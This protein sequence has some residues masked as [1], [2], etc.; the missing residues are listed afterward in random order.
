MA[1]TNEAVNLE[2]TIESLP[3]SPIAGTPAGQSYEPAKGSSVDLKAL[4]ESPEFEAFIDKKVQSKQDKRLGQYG[5]KLES[6]EEAISQF[7]ALTKGGMSEPEALAKMRGDQTLAELKAEVASLR[8]NVAVP[9]AGAGEKSWGERQQAILDNAG[10]DKNDPRIVELLR[11]ATS[12]QDFIAKLEANTFVWKQADVKKPVPSSSTVA[13][14]IPSV[15]AGDGT[16]TASKYKQDMIAARGNSDEL[17]RI[18][19]AAIAD[20]VDVNNIGFV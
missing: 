5:T 7:S 12:K 9:S 20:G 2:P 3:D 16:Y 1:K 14:T 6:L 4:M 18:K 10:I 13:Q 8:G 17:K 15:P 19:A 11:T